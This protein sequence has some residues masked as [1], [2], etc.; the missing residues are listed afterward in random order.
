MK[1]QKEDLHKYQLRMINW[2][3]EN[4][5]C[6]IWAGVGLGKTAT[7]LTAISDLLQENNTYVHSSLINK[8]L[9]IAPLRVAKYVWPVEITKWEHLSQLSCTVI[10]L[11]LIHISEPTRIGMI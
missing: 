2:I 11:S 9:I 6:A 7:T 3:K 4:K 5:K 8:V 10:R 1:R